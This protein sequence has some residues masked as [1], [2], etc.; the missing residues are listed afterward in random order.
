MPEPRPLGNVA[1]VV[2]EHIEKALSQNNGAFFSIVILLHAGEEARAMQALQEAASRND[3]AV[4]ALTLLRADQMKAAEDLIL[5]AELE[6][7][8]DEPGE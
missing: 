2:L 3:F 8:P 7:K 4:R 1:K 5:Q 6:R